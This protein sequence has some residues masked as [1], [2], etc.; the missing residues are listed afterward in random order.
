MVH[1]KKLLAAFAAIAFGFTLAAVPA[2]AA[3]VAPP[4][5]PGGAPASMPPGKP[6]VVPKG[7]IANPSGRPVKAGVPVPGKA[8]GGRVT[9]GL[10]TEPGVSTS[11]TTAKASGDVSTLA[12]CPPTCYFYN[13]GQQGNAASTGKSGAWATLK[14]GGHQGALHYADDHH[15]LGEVAVTQDGSHKNVVEIGWTVDPAVNGTYKPTL[16]VFSW[17]NAVGGVYNGGTFV[18][19]VGAA[20][21]PG[22]TQYT[23]GSN[24]T[25]GFYHQGPGTA[26]AQGWWAH[27]NGNWIGYYPDSDWDNAVPAQTNFKTAEFYQFFFEIASKEL[28]PCSDLGLGLVGSNVNAARF[29]T[30][31]YY[32]NTGVSS[33]TGVNLNTVRSPA[34]EAGPPYANTFGEGPAGAQRAFRGGGP[35]WNQ[36]GTGVGIVGHVGTSCG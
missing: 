6:V 30:V 10:P 16:F 18:P 27:V 25:M 17:I 3:P 34:V 36:L 15:T 19:L 21:V 7:Y 14:V 2:Q 5:S 26:T 9:K 23:P 32:D 20:D 1:S 29:S 11:G 35:M 31:S 24:V 13:S 8:L 4:A 33:G 22:V 28:K 12:T